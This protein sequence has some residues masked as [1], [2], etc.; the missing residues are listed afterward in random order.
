MKQKFLVA[1]LAGRGPFCKY[2]DEKFKTVFWSNERQ[3]VI[4]FVNRPEFP[5]WNPKHFSVEHN[6]MPYENTKSNMASLKNYILDWA[7]F[8][9]YTQ[10]WMIDENISRMCKFG[11]Y[12]QEDLAINKT[13]PY[14]KW[15]PLPEIEN[16]YGGMTGS[17]F[18][19][20][21]ILRDTEYCH[22]SPASIHYW[23]FNKM[24]EITG[25]KIIYHTT[26][27][28]MWE[29][30]D[31]FL[32]LLKYNIRPMTYIKYTGQKATSQDSRVKKGSLFSAGDEKTAMLGFNLYRK[33]GSENVLAV[34]KINMVDVTIKRGLSALR[35]ISFRWR[36][37]SLD[38]FLQD[39][40]D[41]TDTYYARDSEKAGREEYQW[42]NL[43]R[44]TT[45]KGFR[46]GV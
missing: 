30:Y 35:P 24:R 11:P 32:E 29:D 6:G 31:Y 40:L 17:N 25:G 3:D 26:N 22:M 36:T 18:I 7:D 34:R 9:G 2:D 27:E 21:R 20:N 1:I 33:W 16:A 4:A 10:L 43:I 5:D 45:P 12:T 42:V 44:N 13:V 19:K 23:D 15:D 8:H 39:V 14:T 28:M 37:D 38:N 46:F 41:E